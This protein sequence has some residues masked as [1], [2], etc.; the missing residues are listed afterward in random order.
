MAAMFSKRGEGDFGGAP[1][2]GRPV[3]ARSHPGEG[4]ETP[5]KP[6]KSGNLA[7]LATLDLPSS[8][9]RSICNP[10]FPPHSLPPCRNLPSLMLAAWLRLP[11]PG[12]LSHLFFTNF[13]PHLRSMLTHCP[14]LECFPRCAGC[15][16]FV[17]HCKAWFVILSC[18]AYTW[19]TC[20]IGRLS[21][22]MP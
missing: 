2:N 5:I 3:G 10:L 9:T 4:V 19:L 11:P 18:C 20:C 14:T 8:K 6:W 21:L 12:R 17:R 13:F 22:S 16:A 7:A 1:R 15:C